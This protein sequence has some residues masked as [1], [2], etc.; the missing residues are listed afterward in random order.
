MVVFY[1]IN[2]KLFKIGRGSMNCQLKFV[3]LIMVLVNI[4]LFLIGATLLGEGIDLLVAR[5]FQNFT[6]LILTVEDS[7]IRQNRMASDEILYIVLIFPGIMFLLIGFLGCS[8]ATTGVECLLFFYSF[9]I[10][11]NLVFQLI[12]TISLIVFPV[13]LREKFIFTI[14]SLIREKYKGPIEQDLQLA[15]YL[16]DLVM[17]QL[18][19]C[20]IESKHDF[21]IT[22]SWNR[23]NPWWKSPMSME[24]KDFKYPLTC[25]PMNSNS[26]GKDLQVFQKAI[27]CAINGSDIYEIGCY[28]KIVDV[29]SSNQRIIF[30]IVAFIFII[31]MTAL[32]FV[33]VIYNR[34]RM[35]RIDYTMEALPPPYSARTRRNNS[36]LYFRI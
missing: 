30:I 21:D 13:E 1:L 9:G 8:G 25:C 2:L 27:N 24:K 4:I 29:V 14:R 17:H 22:K 20:G 6:E 31:E 16:W 12:I 7:N 35:R 26:S 19:C 3:R 28:R 23:T 18:Q 34:N 33:L 36:H 10:V 32:V 15:S 5:R 11:M